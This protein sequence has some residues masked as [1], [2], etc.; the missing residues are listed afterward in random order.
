MS[1]DRKPSRWRRLFPAAGQHYELFDASF[2]LLALGGIGYVM[3]EPNPNAASAL[4]ILRFV[5]EEA[6]GW[7]LAFAAIVGIVFSYTRWL[8]VGYVATI[9]ATL[10]MSGFFA[11]GY[12][13]ND[14]AGIRA[15]L[16]AVIYGWIARRLIR[17][18]G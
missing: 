8:R 18:A 12:I 1:D 15:L 17:D 4:T 3:S 2:L 5:S 6:L 13:T 14:D 11:I 7:S 9:T 16:S 10:A